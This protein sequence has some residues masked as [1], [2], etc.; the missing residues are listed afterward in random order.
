MSNKQAAKFSVMEQTFD[1]GV[2]CCC[3]GPERPGT[4]NLV[5]PLRC[6][7][8]QALASLR[9]ITLVT[10]HSRHPSNI[11]HTISC[12]CVMKDNW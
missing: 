6:W 2:V 9:G 11:D 4:D 8:R 12:F 3:F 10:L 7:R 1:G 5:S